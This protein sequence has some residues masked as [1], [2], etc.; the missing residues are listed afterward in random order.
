MRSK[1]SARRPYGSGS[2]HEYRGGWYAKWRIGDRQIKRKIGPKRTP[3]TRLGLTRSQAERELHRI[4]QAETA[5][6]VAERTS[7]REAGER[8]LHHVEFVMERKP[9]TVQDYRIMLDR[10]LSPF[11]GERAIDKVTGD[12]VAAYMQ[13]KRREGLSSK[14]ISNHLTFLHGVMGYAVKRGWAATNPVAAVD[15]PRPKGGDPD[16]RFLDM[17]EFEALLRTVPDDEFGPMERVLYLAAATTGLRQG[18]L[19]A[20]RWQDVDWTAGLIR[21]R[22]NR[23]RG[24]WGTPK[25]RRSSRAVP[26]IDRLAGELDRHFQRSAYQA[27]T[28]LVF[29]HPE[30]GHPYDVSKLRK[31][32]KE[33][34]R[35]ARVRPVRFHDLRHTF[36][37]GVAGAGVPM[38]TLQEWMGHRSSQTTE[39]YADYSP[40]SQ[41][42]AWAER[43]FAGTNSSTNVS[44]IESNSDQPKPH[45]N[46][47]AA[48]GA[49][50]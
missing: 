10:H 15:R 26:M 48:P 35:R 39:I 30:T 2:L 3:G 8:Y 28:G 32:Y 24:K 13:A 47:K 6:P 46:G 18:E 49:T 25:S 40:H 20:L 21:V 11:L 38:R 16:I 37:T 34:L 45:Q 41:E 19:V 43:A 33:A 14:T 36:G 5:A 17:S 50:A 42:R 12:H 31:R 27:D 9:S 29:C 4:M 23:V 44:A 7:I 22:R 1:R